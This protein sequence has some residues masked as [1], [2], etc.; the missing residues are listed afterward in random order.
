M[1]D[2]AIN[3]PRCQQTPAQAREIEPD[4]HGDATEDKIG[5]EKKGRTRK[6]IGYTPLSAATTRSRPAC[7]A[8]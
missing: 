8:A 1:L 2:N 7:L 6:L 3:E 4:A 5:T